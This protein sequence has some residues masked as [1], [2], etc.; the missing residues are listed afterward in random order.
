MPDGP[1]PEDFMAMGLFIYEFS[2][3][4]RAINEALAAALAIVAAPGG[5]ASRSWLLWEARADASHDPPNQ[6]ADEGLSIGGGASVARTQKLRPMR[7]DIAHG[8]FDEYQHD[9]LAGAERAATLRRELIASMGW[10][11]TPS[12]PPAWSLVWEWRR[13]RGEAAEAAF[14]A[15]GGGRLLILAADPETTA[16]I[17]V[18]EV[19]IAMGSATGLG[20]GISRRGRGLVGASPA[21]RAIG[22]MHRPCSLRTLRRRR[23][24]E[25]AKRGANDK[26]RRK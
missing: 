10:R 9:I 5:G 24:S 11:G 3:L 20:A 13:A 26:N 2:R 18:A 8:R 4:D 21:W 23:L 7:N 6:A 14:K 1:R 17:K 12:P 15:L 19:S 22:R 25:R 16:D